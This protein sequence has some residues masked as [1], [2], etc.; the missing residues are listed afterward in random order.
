MAT[1]TNQ[2]DPTINKPSQPINKN[3]K[4]KYDDF[5]G[6][7]PGDGAEKPLGN[8]AERVILD[9]LDIVEQQKKRLATEVMTLFTENEALGTEI[10][11][12]GTEIENLVIENILLRVALLS[13]MG[14]RN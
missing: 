7:I 6:T 5:V 10:E 13:L 1:T 8:R 2:A 14:A 11:N 4:R 12:L 3:K 9:Y